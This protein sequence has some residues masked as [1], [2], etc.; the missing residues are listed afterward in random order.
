VS[1][2]VDV[3]VAALGLSEVRSVIGAIRRADLRGA[4]LA[5]SAAVADASRPATTREPAAQFARFEPRRV[6]H[7]APRYEPRPVY[8][9]TPR[10]EAKLLDARDTAPACEPVVVVVEKDPAALPLQPPWKTVPW[11][12]LP[13]TS[14][15]VK[16]ARYR[17][18]IS[19]KGILL[20]FFI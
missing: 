6:V 15:K 11:E 4:E 5:G 13:Q 18:D 17:P 10:L 12:N 8:H 19:P 3:I 9:P 20:D 16:V 7:P 1:T 14:P 2:G